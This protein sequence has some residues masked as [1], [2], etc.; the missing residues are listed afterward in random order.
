[1]RVWLVVGMALSLCA[2]VEDAREAVQKAHSLYQQGR[3]QEAEKLLEQH[4][5]SADPL[6]A[7][8]ALSDLAVIQQD[9]GRIREAERTYRNA[10]RQIEKIA[11]KDARQTLKIRTSGNLAG[12]YL[13]DNR[14][15]KA[16]RILRAIPMAELP[17]GEDSARIRGTTASLYMVRGRARE[18]EEMYLSVLDFWRR[19]P[20][21][22]DA[23][24]VLNNLAVLAMERKDSETALSRLEESLEHWKASGLASHPLTIRTLS[25]YGWILL[26]R[27]QAEQAKAA[28]EQAI[29]IARAWFEADSKV[30]ANLSMLYAQAL[31]ATG[32]RRQAKAIR[33]SVLGEQGYDPGKH[34]VDVLDL[35]RSR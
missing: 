19:A 14:P 8:I 18:A 3:L 33:A 26:E 12:L 16:E 28:L 10:L 15:G 31:E 4:T 35:R 24:V 21:R 25:N 29:R 6:A 27:R 30:T 7:S 2:Q 34:T 20:R 9:T 11:E 22:T 32:D 23:A 13:E 1:M 17:P 5:G